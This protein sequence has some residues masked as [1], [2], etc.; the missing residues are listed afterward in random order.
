MANRLFS[1]FA[2]FLWNLEQNKNLRLT[3]LVVNGV[4]VPVAGQGL[5]FS[6][7]PAPLIQA[8]NRD[9]GTFLNISVQAGLYNFKIGSTTV[10]QITDLGLGCETG[11]FKPPQYTLTSL[12]NASVHNRRLIVVTNATGGPKLC[13]SNGTNWL[14]VSDDAIVS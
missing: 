11:T 2:P 9:T 4:D 14:R 1:L 3:G 10:A 12:P 13:I 8:V 6:G 7:G 5:E